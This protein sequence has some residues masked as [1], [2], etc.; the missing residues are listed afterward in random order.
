MIYIKKIDFSNIATILSFLY[1]LL[2]ME[3]IFEL[4][5]NEYDIPENTS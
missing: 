5:V 4:T 1:H 3:F 2:G